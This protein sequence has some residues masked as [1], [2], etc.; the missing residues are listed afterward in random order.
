MKKIDM[1]ISISIEGIE[2]ETLEEFSQV[3]ERMLDKYKAR[4]FDYLVQRLS[5]ATARFVV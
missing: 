2:T 5:R 3:I 1:D 4:R